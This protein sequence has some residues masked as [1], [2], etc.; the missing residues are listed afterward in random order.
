MLIKLLWPPFFV[1]LSFKDAIL[2]GTK[3]V[4]LANNIISMK[5]CWLSFKIIIILIQCIHHVWKQTSFFAPLTPIH[6]HGHLKPFIFRDTVKKALFE[7][8][9]YVT[10]AWWSMYMYIIFFNT[11][12]KH[13]AFLECTFLVRFVSANN[14][15]LY[16]CTIQPSTNH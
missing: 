14:P 2:P 1:S 7:L 8:C 10:V 16:F 4:L 9:D 12:G 15:M 13:F 11:V 5:L 6:F 3:Y